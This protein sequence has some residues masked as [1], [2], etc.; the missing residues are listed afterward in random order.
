[1]KT[2]FPSEIGLTSKVLDIR[3]DRQNIVMSNLANADIPQYKARRIEFEEELQS[4]LGRDARGKMTQTTKEHMP[5]VFNPN[6]FEGEF[7]EKWKPR[8]VAG[9]DAVDLDKEMTIMAK[10]TLMYDAL[11]QVIKKN[12]EGMKNVIQS[13]SR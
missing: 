1:M 4:A 5:S 6:T 13:G 3:L 7:E 2:F 11:T 12:F 8:A 10:N 9:A